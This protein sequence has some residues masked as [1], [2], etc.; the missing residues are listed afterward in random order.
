VSAPSLPALL[1]SH[2]RISSGLDLEAVA[3][4]AIYLWGVRRARRPWPVLRTG[5]FLA[6]VACVLSALQSG[7]DA[8]DDRLLSVHMTQHMLLALVAPLLL[9]GG[10]PANLALRALPARARSS[11]ARGLSRAGR[12]A[13]PLQCLTVFYLVLLLTHLPAFYD[14]A[15][16]HPALH[17]AEHAAYLLAGLALWWPLLDGDPAPSRRLG[18][19]GRLVYMLAAMPPM[20]LLGAYLNRHASLVYA[21]YGQPARALGVSAIADQAQ[22]GAI[23]WVAGNVIVMAVGLWAAMSALV[24]AERRQQIRETRA[25][26]GQ[27]T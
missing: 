17:A 18:G 8:Y 7:L 4:A 5:S 3:V 10:R 22:A 20:A 1:F 12:H 19:L 15:V 27:R 13:G 11:L 25:L 14:A 23:M 21:L 2:W 6:G 26:E 16:R 9:L 24:A